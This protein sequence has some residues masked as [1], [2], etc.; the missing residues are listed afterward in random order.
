MTSPWPATDSVNQS[1]S[2]IPD[3]CV[4]LGVNATIPWDN[5]RNL[6]SM[7]D[8]HLI[9]RLKSAIFIPLLYLVGAPANVVNMVVFFRQGL[10]ERINVCLFSL[11]LVDL[12][13]L[14]L[15]FVFYA[16]RLYTQFTDGGKYGSVYRYMMNNNVIGLYGFGY[17]PPLLA[18][19]ISTERCVCVLFPLRAQRCIPTKA[20]AIV[21]V[22]SVAVLGFLR[23]VITAQY[24]V[25]CFYETR[26]QRQ[27]WQ[28]YVTDYHFRNKAMLSA[29]NGVFYGFV[30]SVGCPVVV[31]ITTTVTAVRLQRTVRWRSQASSSVSSAKEI[32]V[33]KMLMALSAEFFVLSIPIVVL[34]V[35][36]VFQPQFSPG[37]R[38]AN[39][40][41]AL[42]G[43]AEL[44]SYTSSSLNFFVYYFTG[45]KYRQALHGLTGKVTLSNNLGQCKAASVSTIIAR[46]VNSVK[47]TDM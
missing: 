36:P 23:F 43:F 1:T 6:I 25:T 20:L 2:G 42:L 13:Y 9:D 32:G 7:E 45:T 18:A 14:T 19:I 24:R 10:R 44:C 12:L 29:L 15:L 8:E 33:T 27:S 22:V 30:L 41:L 31:L 38:Y 34:R 37:G 3:H 46:S 28:V 17:G 16:E 26:S 21:I 11:A 4:I 47:E 5:P 39:T 40:F 35:S